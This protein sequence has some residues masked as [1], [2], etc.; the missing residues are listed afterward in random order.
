MLRRF[1]DNGDWIKDIRSNWPNGKYS[2][3]DK[4]EHEG[5]LVVWS[6]YEHEVFNFQDTM[7]VLGYISTTSNVSGSADIYCDNNIIIPNG[8]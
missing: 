6:F 8:I 3:K 2:V 1:D 4:K 5:M 7:S